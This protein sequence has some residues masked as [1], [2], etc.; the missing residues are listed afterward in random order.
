[1]WWHWIC[2][3]R[4]EESNGQGLSDDPASPHLLLFTFKTVTAM[5][6]DECCQWRGRFR[7][8]RAHVLRKSCCSKWHHASTSVQKQCCRNLSS[9]ILGCV[10]LLVSW[11]HYRYLNT[12]PNTSQKH[13][14]YVY[15]HYKHQ[16]AFLSK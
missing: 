14:N 5:T 3:S 9:N 13:A 8:A 6:L 16:T 12:E 11:C 10:I 15:F 1:M 7:W 2:P 4:R